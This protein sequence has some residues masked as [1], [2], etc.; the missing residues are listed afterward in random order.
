MNAG[1]YDAFGMIMELPEAIY[2][3]LPAVLRIAE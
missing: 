3:Y 2:I 1:D